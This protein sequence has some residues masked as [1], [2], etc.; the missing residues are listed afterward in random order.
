[1][2]RC[3]SKTGQFHRD[4][5]EEDQDAVLF[6]E[7][8]RYLALAL[9]DGV[10]ACR[11]AG[12]GARAACDTA[13]ALLLEYGD[14]FFSRGGEAAAEWLLDQTS[15]ELAERFGGT[16]LPLEEYSSTLACVLLDR[17]AERCLYF[18]VGDSLILTAGAE[19]CR[20]VAAPD[21]CRAGC[22]CTTTR[23]ALLRAK[24]GTVDLADC[25]SLLLCSDGAW[26]LMYEND[27]LKPEVAELL[28]EGRGLEGYLNER[29][30]RDDCSVICCELRS[31]GGTG[32]E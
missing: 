30:N 29:E 19:G 20:E 16:G 24:T 22:C 26:R 32:Y 31:T 7:R 23:N 8:G 5:G 6:G 3:F 10:S 2:V 17:Q 21:V 4:R 13:V 18:S 9:A 27:R 14:L 11:A 1:M 15:Y 12:A 28:Q 25:H